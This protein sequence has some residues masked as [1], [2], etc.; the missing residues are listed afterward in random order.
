MQ[1]FSQVKC[2]EIKQQLLLPLLEVQPSEFLWFLTMGSSRCNNRGIN[3]IC[4]G[5]V[6]NCIKNIDI[7]KRLK[8]IRLKIVILEL[9][10]M[11]GQIIT[12]NK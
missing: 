5:H 8:R 9:S 3:N 1:H 6:I 7:S 10:Q 12:Y 2:C 4:K 11:Y